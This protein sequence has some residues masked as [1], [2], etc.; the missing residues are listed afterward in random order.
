MFRKIFPGLLVIFF[1]FESCTSV[2]VLVTYL[3]TLKI[4]AIHR[5]VDQESFEYSDQPI[6]DDT[7]VDLSLW[8]ERTEQEVNGVC[9]H[10]SGISLSL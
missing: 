6:R 9:S 8:G 10:V 3:L 1:N 4:K 5:R 7:T 2:D